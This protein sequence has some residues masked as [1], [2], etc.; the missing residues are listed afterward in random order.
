MAASQQ[1]PE[2]IVIVGPTA[3]GKSDLALQIAKEFNGEIICADS[4]TIYKDMDIGTAK[5]S[6]EEQERVKHWGLDLIAPGEIYSV[7]D[8]KTYAKA[9]IID[10]QKRGKLPILVGGTGLYIDSVIYNFKFRSAADNKLRSKLDSLSIEDL[11][12]TITDAG[13]AMPENTKNKRYL[14]RT[15]EAAGA[16]SERSKKSVYDCLIVGV[17]PSDEELK[18]RI[19]KR[20]QDMFDNGV[21]DETKR[22][23]AKYGR[24][25]INKTSGLVYGL[26]LRVIDHEIS[27]AEAIELFITKDWQYAKRQR[28]WF[29]RNPDIHW[30]SDKVSAKKLI[31]KSLN[32]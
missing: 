5:P 3:S 13:Y 31:E 25:S 11:Q 8:F 26:C 29:K 17:N 10:I 28:T 9:K 12:K 32:T 1:K 19:S 24:R 4:R 18:S 27:S 15:I 22:L 16:A 7:S 14:I 6:A 23:I 2:L 21:V 20:A 30:N